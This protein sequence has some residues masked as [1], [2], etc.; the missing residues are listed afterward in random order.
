MRCISPHANYSIQVIEGLETVMMDGRGHAF[1]QVT[2]KPVIADFQ[3]GGLLDHEIDSA[4]TYFNFSGIPEGVNP[5]TKI[6][7]FDTE[8]YVQRFPEEEQL[9]ILEKIDKRMRQLAEQN[10]GEF[11]VVDQPAAEKPWP[12]YDEDSAKDIL[13]LQERMKFDPE[14]IRRYEV[15]NQNR[16]EIVEKMFGIENPS[17]AAEE[18]IVVGA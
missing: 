14:V 8:S 17:L 4:L 16:A 10:P 2:N 6:S 13:Q 11:I 18:R 1:T 15:E 7:S 12:T 9:A 5:L 3:Q